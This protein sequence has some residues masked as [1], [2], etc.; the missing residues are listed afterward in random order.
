MTGPLPPIR[1]VVVVDLVVVVVGGRVVVG[2]VVVVV[3]VLFG[4]RPLLSPFLPAASAWPWQAATP[5]CSQ[6]PSTLF[7]QARG[8]PPAPTH[9]ATSSRHA[10]LHCRE[11]DAASAERATGSAASSVSS[12]ANPRVFS[13]CPI[14][15]SSSLPEPRSGTSVAGDHVQP[16]N[17]P[18]ALCIVRGRAGRCVR[19]TGI[20]LT[21][22]VALA[23][24][25]SG[26]VTV[27]TLATEC[28]RTP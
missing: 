16:S 24:K 20:R 7:R 18:Q 11:T 9:A 5:S 4:C 6:R 22:L 3:V 10:R 27:W 2:E 19:G 26:S 1:V 14:S 13:R 15:T 17:H 28:I 25:L 8:W 12:D 21:R 23:P